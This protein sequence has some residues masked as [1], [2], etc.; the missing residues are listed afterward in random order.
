MPQERWG[1]HPSRRHGQ[2]VVPLD[3]VI[4]DPSSSR[5]DLYAKLHDVYGSYR[6]YKDST[7]APVY[8]QGVQAVTEL[9]VAKEIRESVDQ[10]NRTTKT[11]GQAQTLI[12]ILQFL[13]SLGLVAVTY[14]L[15]LA[16]TKLGGM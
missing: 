7:S 10:V 2:E 15:Y 12:A 8:Q 9:I 1:I 3:E 14:L 5:E 16:T 4:P 11:Q 13:A 6:G